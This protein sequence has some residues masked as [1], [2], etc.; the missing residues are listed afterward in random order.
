MKS[1][2][3]D[4]RQLDTLGRVVLPKK[5]RTA[6]GISENDNLRIS[7]ESNAIVI[8]REVPLCAICRRDRDLTQIG[9]SYVCLA[10]AKEIASKI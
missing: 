7:L 8:R 6:L 3:S 4:I 9:S 2:T 5:M 10:C 1:E